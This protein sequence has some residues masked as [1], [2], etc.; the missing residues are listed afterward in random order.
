MHLKYE[1]ICLPLHTSLD[2]K[3]IDKI[4]YLIKNINLMKEQLIGG[5][6]DHIEF[7]KLR[8]LDLCII[9]DFLP[10]PIAKREADLFI[11][12][13]SDKNKQTTS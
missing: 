4:I 11:N 5:T 1:D 13:S 3:I 2:T 7:Q 9:I 6:N 12:E 8:K 10:N